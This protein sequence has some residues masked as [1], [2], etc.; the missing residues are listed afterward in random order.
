MEMTME[1][2]KTTTAGLLTLG[3]AVLTVVAAVLS[4]GD[5]G[6]AVINVLL[7]ALAGLGLIGASDGNI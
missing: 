4:G 2:K 7:P 5:V 1:N 3:G 6:A